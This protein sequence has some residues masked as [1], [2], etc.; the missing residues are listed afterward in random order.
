MEGQCGQRPWAGPPAVF[1]SRKGDLQKAKK[2]TKT[3]G[4]V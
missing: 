2:T 1:W 3:Q 4:R